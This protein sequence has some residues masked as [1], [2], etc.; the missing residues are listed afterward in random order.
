MCQQCKRFLN[1]KKYIANQKSCAECLIKKR[2]NAK[3]RRQNKHEVTGLARLIAHWQGYV[4]TYATTNAMSK[5][6]KKPI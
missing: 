1:V 3:A 2:A 5:W 6:I 4:A